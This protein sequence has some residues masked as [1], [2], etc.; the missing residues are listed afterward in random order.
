VVEGGVEE[1]EAEEGEVEE[2]EV[3]E[4]EDVEQTV[5]GKGPEEDAV[6][7]EGV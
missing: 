2:G 7:S 3:G 5:V 1:G 4:G 6:G